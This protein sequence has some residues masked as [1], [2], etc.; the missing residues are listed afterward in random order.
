M[1]IS[2]W[3]LPALFHA[4]AAGVQQAIRKQLLSVASSF[5]LG[6]LLFGS[7]GAMLLVVHVVVTGS[8]WF[9]KI[10]TNFWLMMIVFVGANS[11]AAICSLQVLSAT[12]LSEA[13]LTV[14]LS[15]GL[16]VLADWMWFGQLPPTMGWIGI[17]LLILGAFL[18]MNPGGTKLSDE[19]K[20]KK[21]G[22]L[23]KS[24]VAMGIYNY[25]TPV[26][27]KYCALATSATFS[28]W[29]AHVLIAVTLLTAYAVLCIRGK[30][31]W[32]LNHG[33]MPVRKFWIGIA[34]IAF[35]TGASNV[36]LSWSFQMGGS[37]SGALL[38][39]RVIPPMVAFLIAIYMERR[40]AETKLTPRMVLS[41]IVSS[42]GS[43]MVASK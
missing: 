19:S 39:K 24:F 37:I 15:G 30:A 40:N 35:F 33:E 6:A 29:I 1:I 21:A 22:L 43:V 26:A 36:L 31:M 23:A 11:V 17:A 20:K 5:Q 12:K 3:L 28:A 10:P 18:F 9:D 13:M 4:V 2:V 7:A 25:V 42:V 14:V 8:I 41:M 16:L 38:M 32:T 27:N 34:V